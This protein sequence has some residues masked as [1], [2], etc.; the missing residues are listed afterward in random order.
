[1]DIELYLRRIGYCGSREPTT[2]TLKQLHRAHMLAV[3]FEN[4]DILLGHPINL[5]LASFYDKIV[6]HRRGGFC[7]ELNGLHRL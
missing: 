6:Q 2:E 4:L 7:Y 1:M 3:P 5:S